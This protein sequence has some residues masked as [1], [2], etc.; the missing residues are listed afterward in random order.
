MTPQTSDI[1]EPPRR[2]RHRTLAIVAGVSGLIIAAVM[3]FL[4]LFDWNWLRGPIGRYASA[5]TGRY[6]RL[7]GNLRVHLLSWEPEAF[8]GGLKIGNPGWVGAGD[9]VDQL[10]VKVKLASLLSG[11]VELPLVDLERPHID[12]IRDAQDHANWRLSDK[13]S[14]KPAALPP[15]QQFI[16][17]DGKLTMNDLRR[18]LTLSGTINANEQVGAGHEGFRLQGRGTLNKEPF[19]L[20]ASGGPLVHVEQNKP[21]PFHVDMTAGK[22]RLLA[23]GQLA[24]PFNFGDFKGLLS[25]QGPNLAD[26]YVLTSIPFPATPAYK[27]AAQF[28][29]KNTRFEFSG[30]AGSIG[31]SDLEG[32]LVVDKVNMRRKVTADLQ[33]RRL[34][35]SDLLAVIGG[36]PKAGVVKASANAPPPTR[37]GR[38]MPDATL[39]KDRLRAMDA[40]L[41]YRA[42]S[43]VTSKY[44]LRK[45]SL[46]LTLDDGL[47]A[48]NPIA[49]DFPQGRLA[50]TV[51]IDG[52]KAVPTTDLDVRL[53]NLALQQFWPA[54]AG[55]PPALEG[56]LEA[57]AQLHGVGDSIHKA[58]AT[59]QGKVVL[60]APHGRIRQAFAELLGIN[61]ANG[62]YLLLSKDNRETDLRCAVAQFDV[63]NGLMTVNNAV[64]DT[65][66]V[67]ATGKGSI[68][69]G[70]ETLDLSLEGQPKKPRILRVW[71]PILIKGTMLHPRLG[72]DAAKVAGQAGIAAIVGS[73]LAPL[74]AILPFVDGG[75]AKDAD[76]AALIGEAKAQGA[77]VK[78][79]AIAASV[80][81]SPPK[82]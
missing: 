25:I 64:F 39:Y 45:F 82:R 35:F 59:A 41:R 12:L 58:A 32:K 21:Y 9:T 2:H 63:K 53:T 14:D 71:A 7:E 22:T 13:P 50:G 4:L 6:V 57:R 54:K 72:V 52:R 80:A 74:A 65:G 26:L 1:D 15:I 18:N 17:R 16:I 11:R 42:T 55:Q 78:A 48:M 8:V 27:L 30:I 24:K 49:F 28:D 44:P 73:V 60:V 3:I 69:L 66:V 75:L 68:N 10:I 31:D 19:L 62:L 61:I 37:S 40:Q 47:L 70:E 43:V 36:G 5:R 67:R 51:R 46:D 76:C 81:A 38:M 79:S 56:M 29:R 23:N 20:T 77:P 34:V 33:S